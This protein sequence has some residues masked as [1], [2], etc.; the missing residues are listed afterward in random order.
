M[1]PGGGMDSGRI[2]SKRKISE[3]HHDASKSDCR[4][5]EKDEDKAQLCPGMCIAP[6]LA[7]SLG[8][9]HDFGLVRIEISDM[10][11]DL[12]SW[13]Y[14]ML[15]THFRWTCASALGNS[16]QRLL[17]GWKARGVADTL[18]YSIIGRLAEES[19]IDEA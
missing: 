19:N 13:Y 1:P 3:V 16:I 14:W 4:F 18:H 10:V 7:T 8:I 9:M 15:E 2:D 5:F 12:Y 17:Y 6:L 11:S